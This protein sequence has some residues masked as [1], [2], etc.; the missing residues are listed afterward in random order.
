MK[1]IISALVMSSLLL[2]GQAFAAPDAVVF[3]GGD[4]HITGDGNGL[5]FP[6]GTIQTTKTVKG[7]QGIQGIQGIQGPKGNK[8]DPGVA[9]GISK[10]VHGTVVGSNLP[11]STGSGFTVARTTSV[12]AGSYNITF[13]PAFSTPPDCVITP[14]GHFYDAVSTQYAYIACEVSTLVDPTFSAQRARVECKYYRHLSAI[15]TLID[16]TFTFICVE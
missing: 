2:A 12:P 6:D 15:P 4:V 8:G 3:D 7:D 11:D 5:V 16:A 1:S 10:G 14:V 13:D 9:N